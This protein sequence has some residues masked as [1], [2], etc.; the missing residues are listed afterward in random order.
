MTNH[1][2]AIDKMRAW[3]ALHRTVN[4]TEGMSE[5]AARETM[6]PAIALE[7]AAELL[8]VHDRQGVSLDNWADSEGHGP[9]ELVEYALSATNSGAL[10]KN[11]V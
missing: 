4:P 11:G 2:E 3:A 9:R 8:E 5:A 6:L 10:Q 7:A 1:S